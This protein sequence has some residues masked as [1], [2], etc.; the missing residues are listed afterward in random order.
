MFLTFSLSS[1]NHGGISGHDFH[2]LGGSVFLVTLRPL[3]L[4]LT[5]YCLFLLAS[6]LFFSLC[7]SPSLLWL[8][9][10]VLL[11]LVFEG[12]GLKL[13]Y[14]GAGRARVSRDCS[15]GTVKGFLTLT[16]THC[17]PRG[18][19]KAAPTSVFSIFLHLIS[20]TVFSVYTAFVSESLVK[21]LFSVPFHPL[22]EFT[23]SGGLF[24]HTV[25]GWQMFP[26][27]TYVFFIWLFWDGERTETPP[28]S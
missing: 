21:D 25:I 14:V 2:S 9:G 18:S 7:P 19:H 3:F 22:F 28:L 8:L 5:S 6:L 17:W 1:L 20:V 23:A 13:G 27:L 12:I 11:F 4:P 16:L 24:T 15:S 26:G 10:P